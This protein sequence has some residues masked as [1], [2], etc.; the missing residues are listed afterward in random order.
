MKR[1]HKGQPESRTCISKI[2]NLGMIYSDIS[3]NSVCSYFVKDF[4][5]K[6]AGKTLEQTFPQRGYLND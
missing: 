3:Q 5:E 6:K 2:F 1:K 4:A